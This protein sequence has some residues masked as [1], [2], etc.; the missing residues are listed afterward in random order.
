MVTS[1]MPCPSPAPPAGTDSRYLN[2]WVV[3]SGSLLTTPIIDSRVSGW[4]R[5]IALRCIVSASTQG[6]GAAPPFST[7]CP[8]AAPDFGVYDR[9]IGRLVGA[10][11]HP[12][13][14]G[15]ARRIPRTG[16]NLP[17]VNERFW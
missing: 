1:G 6:F 7:E 13:R 17:L 11:R 10:D 2:L 15:C 8:L 9:C 14:L 4:Q 3:R 16:R 5:L 12:A